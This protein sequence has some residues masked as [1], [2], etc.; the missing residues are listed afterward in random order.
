MKDNYK[1]TSIT[2]EFETHDEISEL[3]ESLKVMKRLLI[4]VTLFHILIITQIVPF[5]V[6]CTLALF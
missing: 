5:T 1:N 3:V 2:I 6:V 4:T